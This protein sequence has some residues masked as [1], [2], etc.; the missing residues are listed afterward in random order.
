MIQVLLQFN[1][2]VSLIL[3][4]LA[5]ALY[6]YAGKL[7]VKRKKIRAGFT[8]FI[9]ALTVSYLSGI[10]YFSKYDEKLLYYTFIF[11]SVFSILGIVL[12]Y[13]SYKKK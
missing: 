6:F 8:M 9:S 2:Q 13:Y 11:C 1:V 3:G 7:M 4:L 12:D 5:I 10:Y